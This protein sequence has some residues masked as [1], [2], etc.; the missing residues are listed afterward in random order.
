MRRYLLDT[1]VAVEYLRGSVAMIRRIEQLEG[2][3]VAFQKS[4]L[5]NLNMEQKK[6]TAQKIID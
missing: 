1:D 2:Q 5:R 3:I 4:Q 6:A